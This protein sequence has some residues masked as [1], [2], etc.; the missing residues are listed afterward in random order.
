MTEEMFEKP[1]LILG[2]NALF[3]AVFVFEIV[4]T[5]IIIRRLRREQ[6]K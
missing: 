6:T 1:G 5:L 2:L 3:F 4:W